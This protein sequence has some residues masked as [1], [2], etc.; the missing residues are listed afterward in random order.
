MLNWNV[1]AVSMDGH[2]EAEMQLYWECQGGLA[3]RLLMGI[4][5]VTVCM[6]RVIRIH[7]LSP[8]DPP[9]RDNSDAQ[10]SG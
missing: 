9:N 2:K 8:P 5:R 6:T 3:S 7:L 10:P 1:P 4:T